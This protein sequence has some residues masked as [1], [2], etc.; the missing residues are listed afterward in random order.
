MK[1]NCVFI[2]DICEKAELLIF[3][4]DAAA[5]TWAFICERSF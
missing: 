3:L 4:P 2:I 5:L 1:R